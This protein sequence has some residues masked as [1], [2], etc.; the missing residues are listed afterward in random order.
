V[1]MDLQMPVMDGFTAT[2]RIRQDLGRT[3]LPIVAMTANAMA[4][5]R[6]ACLAAGMNEHIGKPFD[7]DRLV[8]LL[9]R[10][11]GRAELVLPGEGAPSAAK[12]NT[13]PPAV[14]AAAVAAGVELMPALQRMGGKP[15][16]YARVLRMTLQDFGSLAHT[17][18]QPMTDADVVTAARTLHTVKGLAATL[19]ITALAQEAAAAETKLSVGPS[20]ALAM[21]ICAAVGAAM[22]AALPALS[23]LIER[24]RESEA[25]GAAP[26]TAVASGKSG[27]PAAF[28]QRL[29]EL[30]ALLEQSDMQATELT[31]AM[32]PLVGQSLGPLW[33]QLDDAVGSLDF[34]GASSLC[35][36]L[37]QE[38][39]SP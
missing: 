16:F 12:A 37:L 36:Q 17:L 13:L 7:I 34:E 6:E 39:K 32:R 33:N 14:Q 21:P 25:E 10:L 1:L 28:H 31:L 11:A 30:A 19:G 29:T 15:A 27:D 26:P 5:D 35:Q 9:H 22:A 20:A 24:L 4:S 38:T 18:Q 8:A 23:A 2:A 3:L